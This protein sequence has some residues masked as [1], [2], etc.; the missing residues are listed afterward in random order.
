MSLTSSGLMAIYAI[1]LMSDAS[2]E[3]RVVSRRAEEF[4][5]K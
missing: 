5:R 3:R 1:P 2:F 4:Q